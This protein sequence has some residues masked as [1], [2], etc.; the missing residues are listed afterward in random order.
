MFK[1]ISRSLGVVVE[2]VFKENDVW[3]ASFSD[4]RQKLNECMRICF[5]WKQTMTRLISRWRGDPTHRWEGKDYEDFYLEAMI[6]RLNQIFEL[7]SQHDELLRLLKADGKDMNIESFF[8]PFRQGESF[9]V[10]ND[11]VNDAWKSMRAA[12]E[13]LMEPAEQEICRQLRKEVYADQT[14]TPT[15]RMREFQ[16]WG[17]LMRRPTVQKELRQ[18]RQSVVQEMQAEI[19]KMRD[20]FNSK[21]GAANLDWIPNNERPPQYQNASPVVTAIVWVRQYSQKIDSNIKAA[22]SL[23]SDLDDMQV[24]EQEAGR[25]MKSM[26][27]FENKLFNMW[28]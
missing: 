16:R 12:Y 14:A 3:Q 26:R 15:Q 18:E 25:L 24:L 1:V 7:R 23:F 8:E 20:D 22:K 27:D 21:K 28:H 13:K 6:R 2:R 11:H 10:G 5:N 19:Q 9:Y 4:V 17:G